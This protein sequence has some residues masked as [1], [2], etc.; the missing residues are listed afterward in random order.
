MGF[1]RSGSCS[2]LRMYIDITSEMLVVQEFGCL[3]QNNQKEESFHLS[4]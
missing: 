4:V 1:S 2:W 3:G